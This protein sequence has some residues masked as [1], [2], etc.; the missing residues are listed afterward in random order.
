[1]F[2]GRAGLAAATSLSQA[3]HPS[4]QNNPP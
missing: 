1:V 2:G 4:K 3:R